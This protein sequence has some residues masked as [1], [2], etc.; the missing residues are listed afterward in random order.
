[1]AA[2]SATAT[3]DAASEGQPPD[4]RPAC[5]SLYHH[6]IE[7][8]GKRWTGAI[9]LVLMDGACHFSQ[10]R[11]LVPDI[12]DRLLSERLKELETEGIVDRRVIDGAPVRV[13]YS[14]TDKGRA[15]DPVVRSLKQW[16]HEW[17]G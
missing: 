7:L 5:C 13:E 4:A 14:L 8:I 3:I 12:S 15:L 11:G 16:A 9:L 6:A 10:I 2:R 17:Q 1:M